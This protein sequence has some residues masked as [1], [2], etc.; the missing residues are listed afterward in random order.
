MIR[1]DAY[2][3]TREASTPRFA[4][5]PVDMSAQTN[6]QILLQ[7]LDALG[8]DNEKL[9]DELGRCYQHLGN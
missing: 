7:H 8:A 5:I 3:G 6:P 2:A 4:G 1:K 9:R